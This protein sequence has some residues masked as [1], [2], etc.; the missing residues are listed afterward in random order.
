MSSTNPIAVPSSND[1]TTNVWLSAINWGQS[2]STPG[3]NAVQL[4]YY[5]AGNADGTVAWQQ[6]EIDAKS[7]Q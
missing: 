3:S 4:Y 7:Q 1:V 2:W 5:L 6:P